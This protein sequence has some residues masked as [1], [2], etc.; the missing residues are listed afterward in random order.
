MQDCKSRLG[1]PPLE[2]MASGVP[3]VVQGIPVMHEVT[4]GHAL[5]IDYHDRPAATEALRQALLDSSVRETLI[6]GGIARAAEFSFE[7]LTVERVE[8]LRSILG[9]PPTPLA[10][11]YAPIYSNAFS[12]LPEITT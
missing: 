3:C 10:A 6:S 5:L 12:T 1:P 4:A 9:L 11:K 2:A 8:A 7:R